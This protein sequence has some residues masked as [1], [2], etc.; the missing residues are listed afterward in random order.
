MGK[1]FDKK[2][3]LKKSFS[4]ENDFFA[5]NFF[6]KGVRG[7]NF[8]YKKSFS[9]EKIVKKKLLKKIPANTVGTSR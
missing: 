1:K 5:L 4:I 3:T 8:F 6:E 9:P 2:L 7:K